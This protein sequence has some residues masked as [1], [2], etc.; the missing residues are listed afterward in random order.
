MDVAFHQILTVSSPHHLSIAWY[1][2]FP[3]EYLRPRLVF[4]FAYIL[5]LPGFPFFTADMSNDL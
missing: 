3:D 2:S 4:F 1:A 5:T